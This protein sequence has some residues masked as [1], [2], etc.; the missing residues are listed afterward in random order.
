MNKIDEKEKIIICFKYDRY[1][2]P[3][4][5]KS[6]FNGRLSKFW[7]EQYYDMFKNW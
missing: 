6:S 7:S 2:K 4:S 1:R 3:E 5:K